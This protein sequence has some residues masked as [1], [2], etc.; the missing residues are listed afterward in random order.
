MDGCV[1][2]TVPTKWGKVHVQRVPWV[3]QWRHSRNC[4][5][6][7]YMSLQLGLPAIPA[8]RRLRNDHDELEPDGEHNGLQAGPMD[9]ECL[10]FCFSSLFLETGFICTTAPRTFSVDQAGLEF[11]ELTDS[12]SSALVWEACTNMPRRRLY[13]KGTNKGKRDGFSG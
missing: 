7:I 8:H 2:C 13:L 12:A 9:K 4:D 5:G 1:R 10:Y 6:K 11:R 3:S